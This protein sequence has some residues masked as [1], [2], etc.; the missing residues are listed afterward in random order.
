MQLVVKMFFSLLQQTYYNRPNMQGSA[1]RV[2]PSNTPRSVAPTH[3]YQPTSQVMM[4]PQQQMPYANPQGHAFFIHGQVTYV[5]WTR[6]NH[7]IIC[8]NDACLARLLH[9]F[10]FHCSTVPHT[11][12]RPSSTRYPVDLQVSTLEAVQLNTVHMVRGS[13]LGLPWLF[14][15][16]KPLF[17]V[18]DLNN[19]YICPCTFKHLAYG[20]CVYSLH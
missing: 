20:T 7:T 8:F 18:P 2:P 5:I 1:P 15:S 6:V 14:K 4:I 19:L 9:N 12:P 13:A 17:T 16:P 3:V 11:C 10:V